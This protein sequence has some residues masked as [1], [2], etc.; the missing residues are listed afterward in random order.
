MEGG[1]A[2][3][4]MAGTTVGEETGGGDGV[5]CVHSPVVYNIKWC[6]RG[7][8]CKNVEPMVVPTDSYVDSGTPCNIDIT[9]MAQPNYIYD[10]TATGGSGD[11]MTWTGFNDQCSASLPNGRLCTVAK[12]R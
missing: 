2:V 8:S 3:V 11:G 4:V 7:I 1:G 9:N 10:A 5:G 6:E 12:V